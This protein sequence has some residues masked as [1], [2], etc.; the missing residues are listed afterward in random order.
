MECDQVSEPWYCY[1][2]RCADGSFYVGITNDLEERIRKH[3][4]GLG[5][6]FTKLRRPVELIWSERRADRF[7]AR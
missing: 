4:R 3:N 6:R 2:L 5:P 1:L 7:A